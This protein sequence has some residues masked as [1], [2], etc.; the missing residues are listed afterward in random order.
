M[1]KRGKILRDTSIGDGLLSINGQQYSFTLSGTWK[2]DVAPKL[3]MVVDVQF[4]GENEIESIRGVPD[5]QL[6]KE[7]AEL[8]MSAV[9]V[10]GAQFAS[11]IVAKFG[12]EML[13]AMTLLILGW[14]CLNTISIQVSSSYE[15][16]ITF[17]QILGIVNSS[18]G[19]ISGLGA[20]GLTGSGGIYSVVGA[21]AFL[22]PMA[23]F[24]WRDSRAHLV[25]LLPLLFMIIMIAM[26][27]SGVH[28]GMKQ[29]QNAA[30]TFGGQ[31]AQEMINEMTAEMTTRAMKAI[32]LGIGGY[33]SIAVSVYFAGNGFIK[34]LAKK[35]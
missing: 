18:S 15:I 23:P 32:S 27:Y 28:D 31:Q 25:G 17:W 33:V 16:G 5:S 4:I 20:G 10:R 14:F 26:I 3:D 24:F 8:A 6:A 12:I 21:L 7:Q 13:V 9:K 11:S 29:A 1:Y 30:G 22:A 2:S 34:F 19:V 35:G